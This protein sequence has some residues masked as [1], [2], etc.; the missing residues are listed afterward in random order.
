MFEQSA[1]TRGVE[2]ETY[3]KAL[4]FIRRKSRSEGID[5]A[6][7]DGGEGPL[8]ALIVPVQADSGL[9]N[10][11]AAKAGVFPTSS[12]QLPSRTFSNE[13]GYPMITIPVGRDKNG[14]IIIG[15]PG[16]RQGTLSTEQLLGVPFGLALIHT[17]GR[18]DQ[19]IRYGSAIEDLAGM[20]PRPEFRN[21]EADDYMYVGVKPNSELHIKRKSYIYGERRSL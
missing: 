2:D 17:A 6:L 18:E 12:S 20:R 1:A 3:Q 9:A 5:A 8:D 21:P 16:L 4:R 10:Q 19:L 14:K 13:L 11:V 7:R 15:T